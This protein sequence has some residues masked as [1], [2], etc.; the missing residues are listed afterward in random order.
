M[1]LGQ[2]VVQHDVTV[3][4]DGESQFIRHGTVVELDP[5]G[6]LGQAFGGASNLAP[7]VGSGD[8]ADHV[9]EGN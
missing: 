1:S 8:D 7:L 4:W 6:A 5:S 9:A 2:Y 3:T